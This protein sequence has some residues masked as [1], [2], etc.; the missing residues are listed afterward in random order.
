MDD[1]MDCH[2]SFSDFLYAFQVQSCFDGKK[3]DITV[4][5]ILI[6]LLNCCHI[7]HRNWNESCGE[8][9]EIWIIDT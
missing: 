5:R 2:I 7:L 6:G 9:I 4:M 1:A 8:N 3:C